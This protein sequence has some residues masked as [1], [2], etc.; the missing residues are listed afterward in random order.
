MRCRWGLAVMLAAAIGAGCGPDP[1]GS[2]AAERAEFESSA[3]LR[4][5]AMGAKIDSL[6]IEIDTQ[7]GE[8]REELLRTVDELAYERRRAAAKLEELRNSR[9]EQWQHAKLQ[10]AELL[11]ALDRRLDQARSD[12]RGG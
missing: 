1:G 12:L 6:R 10:A 11:D 4:L 9:E 7:S 5:A 8:A 2:T 3:E